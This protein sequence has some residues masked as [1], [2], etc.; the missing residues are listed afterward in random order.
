MDKHLFLGSQWR[1]GA[2]CYL[3]LNMIQPY[4]LEPIEGKNY[5]EIVGI[6]N[7][8]QIIG[9]WEHRHGEISVIDCDAYRETLDILKE[10]ENK[11]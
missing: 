4:L 9:D 2:E 11:W 8:E 10:I 1:R 3:D 7:D 6:S 5:L